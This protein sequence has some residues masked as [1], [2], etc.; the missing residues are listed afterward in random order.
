MG[1]SHETLCTIVGG[2]LTFFGT[3]YLRQ[4]KVNIYLQSSVSQA[5]PSKELGGDLHFHWEILNF[6]EK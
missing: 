1:K 5:N 4:Q 2:T 3:G 6:Y